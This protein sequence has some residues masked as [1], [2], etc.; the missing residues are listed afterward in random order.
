M[1]NEGTILLT[2]E[3]LLVREEIKDLKKERAALPQRQCVNSYLDSACYE[4][5][6]LTKNE[7]C[8]ECKARHEVSEKIWKLS[9]ENAGRLNRLRNIILKSK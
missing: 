8:D 6:G 1:D 9:R 3:Y 5:G 4:D 2:K 7:W